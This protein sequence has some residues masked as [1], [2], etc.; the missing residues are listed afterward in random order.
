MAGNGENQGFDDAGVLRV[1]AL[2]YLFRVYAL[3]RGRARLP[4]LFYVP[5]HRT[6]NQVGQTIRF[7]S[8]VERLAWRALTDREKLAVCSTSDGSANHARPTTSGVP[9]LD[10]AA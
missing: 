3:T 8:S 5:T 1:N 10:P 2:G 4:G 6:G 7:L 9:S